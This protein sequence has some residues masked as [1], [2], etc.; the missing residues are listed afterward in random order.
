MPKKPIYVLG[1]SATPLKFTSGAVVAIRPIA[2]G[3]K[4]S[5]VLLDH[6]RMTTFKDQ[7]INGL[8]IERHIQSLGYVVA[9]EGDNL[10]NRLESLAAVHDGLALIEAASIKHSV[11]IQKAFAGQRCTYIPFDPDKATEDVVVDHYHGS[12]CVA[13]QFGGLSSGCVSLDYSAC[14][15]VRRLEIQLSEGWIA[16]PDED[17]S[18]FPRNSEYG[19]LV[20]LATF[21][22]ANSGV[23]TL[24]EKRNLL[25]PGD[26]AADDAPFPRGHLVLNMAE[27]TDRIMVIIDA[28]DELVVRYIRDDGEV[29]CE[30]LGME[31][32]QNGELSLRM[33]VGCIASVIIRARDLEERKPARAAKL[34]AA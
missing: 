2:K 33:T 16:G 34:K 3:E 6:G 27:S 32:N 4:H 8:G 18:G 15:D 11:A 19:G 21:V 1:D 9:E 10:A 13:H 29:V 30:H 23:A 7:R 17:V 25:M 26:D 12:T 20:E 24:S 31:A 14:P 22:V 5:V 28:G